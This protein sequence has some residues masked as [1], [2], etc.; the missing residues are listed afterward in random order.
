M[1]DERSIMLKSNE[2]VC[3]FETEDVQLSHRWWMCWE[4]SKRHIKIF[5]PTEN[6]VP[7]LQTL[8]GKYVKNMLLRSQCI[9]GNDQRDCSS[10]NDDKRCKPLIKWYQIRWW[11]KQK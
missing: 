6:Q 3:T 10:A 2:R 8:F 9:H 5:H 7:E 1:T 11:G 4:E